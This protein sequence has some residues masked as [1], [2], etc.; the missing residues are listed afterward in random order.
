MKKETVDRKVKGLL[1]FVAT[2][3]LTWS[4]EDK[5]KYVNYLYMVLNNDE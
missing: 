2:I 1:R 5:N 4:P 3:V